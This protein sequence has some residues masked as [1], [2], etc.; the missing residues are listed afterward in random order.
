M[1]P[2]AHQMDRWNAAKHFIVVDADVVF[3][4]RA[5]VKDLLGEHTRLCVITMPL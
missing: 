4:V 2:S 1:A 5:N 3:I